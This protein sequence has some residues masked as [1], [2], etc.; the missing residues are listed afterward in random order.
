MIFRFE[1]HA[2]VANDYNEAYDWYEQ[3][4]SG[5]GERFLAAVRAKLE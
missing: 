1:F 5:L 4:K 2:E 3:Q